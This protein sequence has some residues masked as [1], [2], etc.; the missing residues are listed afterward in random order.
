MNDDARST[1]VQLGREDDVLTLAR[2][3]AEHDRQKLLAVPVETLAGA[4]TALSPRD[5]AEF[6]ELSER[7]PEI[8]PLLAEAVFT[9]AVIATGIEHAGWLLESATPEQRVAAVDLDCWE[10][11]RPVPERFFEWIDALDEAGTDTLVRAFE[12]LD[13]ELWLLLFKRMATFRFL[14][15]GDWAEL[16]TLDGV[17]GIEAQS[18]EDEDRVLRILRTA[19]S[20]SPEHYWQFVIG[21]MNESPAECH[22]EAAAKQR[23]RLLEL[24][25]PER[26]QAMRVYRPLSLDEITLPTSEA[27]ADEAHALVSR[28]GPVDGT[29]L[30]E[31]LAALAPDRASETLADILVVAN[32]LA[33]AD[34]LPLAEPESVAQALQKAMRGIERGLV[35]LAAQRGR[36]PASLLEHVA[37][38]LLFRAGATL[39]GALRPGKTLAQLEA[40]EDTD[41]WAVPTE[42]ID[43]RDQTLSEDGGLK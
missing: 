8:V 21:S 38:M 31:A 33:V 3:K 41:D 13:L 35:E 7:G 2:S 11:G 6:L 5:R 43:A 18:S 24:G 23:G 10:G 34:E 12:E 36:T 9:S 37:P 42:T 28:A 19:F 15:P 17:V 29:V 26:G 16:P 30:A 14:P 40:E 4:V 1:V 32:S 39:E 25:F 22:E 20:E 27:S